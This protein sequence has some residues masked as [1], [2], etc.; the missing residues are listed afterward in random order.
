MTSFCWRLGQEVQQQVVGDQA[1]KYDIHKLE[2]R[3]GS[4]THQ[5]VRVVHKVLS[6]TGTDSRILRYVDT[7]LLSPATGRH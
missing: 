1:G 7:W 6:M 2:I 5:Y 4:T 3:S